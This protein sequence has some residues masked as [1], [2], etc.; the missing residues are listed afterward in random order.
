MHSCSDICIASG[1]DSLIGLRVPSS[2]NRF[3]LGCHSWFVYS[4]FPFL[5]VFF[6]VKLG[7]FAVVVQL[8]CVRLS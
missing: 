7:W 2:L 8:G 3:W 4:P 1:E 6:I 5:F